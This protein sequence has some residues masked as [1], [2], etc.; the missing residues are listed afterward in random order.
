MYG[1]S[2]S[3]SIR[4]G[5]TLIASVGG[6]VLGILAGLAPGTV[7][8]LLVWLLGTMLAFPDLLLVLL[9]ITVLGY[10]SENTL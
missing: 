3:L 9:A 8:Q 2:L 1:T 10:G 4:V 7:W 5:M 6:T